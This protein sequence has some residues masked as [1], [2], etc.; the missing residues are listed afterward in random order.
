MTTRIHVVNFGPEAVDVKVFN[1]QT[2]EA[3]PERQAPSLFA[4]QSTDVYV[5]D[6]QAITVTEKKPG[7]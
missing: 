5:H 7:A 4:Q 1:P 6:T 2:G 3:D